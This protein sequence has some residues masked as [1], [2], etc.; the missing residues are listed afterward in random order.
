MDEN[1]KEAVREEIEANL[2]WFYVRICKDQIKKTNDNLKKDKKE[3]LSGD[4]KKHFI[5]NFC[6]ENRLPA[7]NEFIEKVT[8]EP[9]IQSI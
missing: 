1:K 4:E 6:V 5:I 9:L 8:K 3:L 7:T 2:S